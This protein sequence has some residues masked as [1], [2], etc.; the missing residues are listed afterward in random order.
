MRLLSHHCPHTS[1]TARWPDDIR[2]WILYGHEQ[3][4]KLAEAQAP[5]LGFRYIRFCR[6]RSCMGEAG[7]FIYKYQFCG[8]VLVA[9]QVKN[10][11][12]VS[13]RWGWIMAKTARTWTWW[14]CD[15]YWSKERDLAEGCIVNYTEARKWKQIYGGRLGDGEGI[16]KPTAIKRSHPEDSQVKIETKHGGIAGL[17]WAPFWFLNLGYVVRLLR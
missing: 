9:E 3:H 12:F 7:G 2:Y 6:W 14:Q 16:Y 4:G 15:K 17:V 10:L 5:P 1:N 11:R 8:L 13:F